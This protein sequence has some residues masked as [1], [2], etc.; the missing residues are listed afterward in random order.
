MWLWE[1]NQWTKAVDDIEK[2]VELLRKGEEKKIILVWQF[3]YMGSPPSNKVKCFLTLIQQE[4][5]DQ[6][7]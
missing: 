4:Y 3:S 5:P 6:L 7:G 2:A 1:D